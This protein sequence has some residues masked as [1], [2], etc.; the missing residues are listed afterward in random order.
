MAKNFES[1]AREKMWE[2]QKG[3]MYKYQNQTETTIKMVN[4]LTC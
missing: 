3:T 4:K 1:Q 2:L